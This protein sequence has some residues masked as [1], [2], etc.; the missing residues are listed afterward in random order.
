MGKE[1]QGLMQTTYAQFQL[2]KNQM[3]NLA[4][5]VGSLLIPPLKTFAEALSEAITP[6]T[7]F[8]QAHQTLAKVLVYPAV[9][10]GLLLTALGSLALAVGWVGKNI[11]DGLVLLTAFA[12]RLQK[13]GLVSRLTAFATMPLNAQLKLLNTRLKA[14]A[15]WSWNSL[16]SLYGWVKSLT[17]AF[18]QANVAVA[19]FTIATLRLQTIEQIKGAFSAVITVI[20]N[21]RK[22]I[23]GFIVTNPYLFVF[24]GIAFLIYKFWK[25]IKAF[26]IG[27]FEGL[28]EGFAEAFAP[29][30]P[31]LSPVISVFKTLFSWI[32]KILKPLDDTEGGFRS[33]AN[34][35]KALG[36]AVSKLIVLF[37]KL[38]TPVANIVFLFKDLGSAIIDG[39]TKGIKEAA[40]K[41]IE[42]VKEVGKGLWNGL[43]SLL[44]ISSPSRVF[45]EI[46]YFLNEGLRIGIEKS[47]GAVKSAIGK[48]ASVLELPAKKEVRLLPELA[49]EGLKT[50]TLPATLVV[51]LLSPVNAVSSPVKE[52]QKIFNTAEVHRIEARELV[53][54]EKIFQTEKLLKAEKVLREKL[55]TERIVRE[56]KAEEIPV[57]NLTLNFSPVINTENKEEIRQVLQTYLPD[58]VRQVEEAIRKIEEQRARRTY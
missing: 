33:V 22:A 1:V 31:I 12:K 19:R 8:I 34:A 44:G 47:I 42:A 50:L 9:G 51:S 14:L 40:H 32:G 4:I 20:G 25:P 36:Y 39:L 24:A 2:L 11:F 5:A 53:K 29:L 35:G 54:S 58:F 37:A 23:L 26:F 55:V 46:G 56:T 57:I 17:I 43:K 10:I 52:I 49:L 21:L 3:Q 6:I 48:V 30:K 7:N 16:K 27:L 28:K 45:M 41:P 13:V 15:S 38:L 18:W